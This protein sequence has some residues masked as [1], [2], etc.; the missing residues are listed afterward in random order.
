[1]T[2]KDPSKWI[3]VFVGRE[4]YSCRSLIEDQADA[5]AAAGINLIIIGLKLRHD[6]LEQAEFY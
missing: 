1:M 3:I 4:E 5:A 6:N 2:F